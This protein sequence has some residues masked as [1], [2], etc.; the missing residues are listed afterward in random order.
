MCGSS[1]PPSTPVDV[2]PA[3][4]SSIALTTTRQVLHTF[5]YYLSLPLNSGPTT[6]SRWMGFPSTWLGP[7]VG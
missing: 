7:G 5:V 1:Y 2:H 6:L 4:S 3:F